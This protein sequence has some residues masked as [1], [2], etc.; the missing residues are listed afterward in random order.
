M[1]LVHNVAQSKPNA[2]AGIAIMSELV[3]T[4]GLPNK[5]LLLSQFV[6]NLLVSLSRTN[7]VDIVAAGSQLAGKNALLR[8]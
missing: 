5:E 8:S 3:K 2:L 7:D 6:T 4:K 1:V